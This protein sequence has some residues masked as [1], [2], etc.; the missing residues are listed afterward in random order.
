[1][2]MKKQIIYTAVFFLGLTGATAQDIHFSQY[3]FSPLTLNPA[4]TSVYKDLQATLNYKDQWHTVNAYRTSEVTF[5]MKLNQKNWIKVDKFTEIYKRKLVKGLAFGINVF[6]D[7]AGDGKLKTTNAN[8]SIA[9]HSLL[10]EHN[11]LSAGIM[12]G[13]VQRSIDPTDLRWNTQYSGGVYDPNINSGENFSNQNFIFGDY[14][15]GLLWSYGEAAHYLTE[16][17]QKYF[18]LGFS[19]AHLNQPKYSFIGS[20]EKLY[21]KYTVHSN[22]LF[23]IKNSH[24]S[25]APSF[26]FMQQGSQREITFGAM[27]KYKLK[28]ESKYTGIIKGT[29]ISAG[30]FYRNRDAVIPY[31]LLEMDKYTIGISYDTNISSLTAATTGRGGFE[32]CLRFGTPSPFLYQNSKARI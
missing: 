23:G 12:G 1:M 10:N 4:M 20:S 18:N 17:D 6:S 11:T 31:F 14:S 30:C 2:G 28:E 27:I 19:L 29:V 13:I 32:I 16:N 9:Y 15:L 24:Y 25:F 26:L 22:M 21:R 7:K 5:E 3:N 8:F